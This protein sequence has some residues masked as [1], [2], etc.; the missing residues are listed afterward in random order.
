MRNRVYALPKI[1]TCEASEV[2]SGVSLVLVGEY[3]RKHKQMFDRYEYLENLYKGYFAI[4]KQPAKE[5]WKPDNRLTVPFPK[6]ITDTFT[7]YGY[8]VPI[9]ETSPNDSINDRLQEFQRDNEIT[10]HE[11]EL[12]KKCCIY[13]HAFEYIYQN[14]EGRTKLTALTPKDIFVVYDDTIKNRALFAVR[15]GYHSDE[16]KNA[17]TP[18]GEVMTASEVYEFD[19]NRITERRPNPYGYIPCVEWRFNDERTGL[20]E[21]VSRLI[22]QYNHTISEKANDVDAFAEAYLAILGAEVDDEDIYR[23]RDKRII[24]FYGTDN[25]QDVL[26]QFLTKPTADATQENLLDRLEQEIY[27]TSMV[28]NISDEAFGNA[29]S[30]VSLAYKL[31]AMSN[32]AKMFDRKIEKSIRKR[33]KVWAS[34]STNTSSPDDYLDIEITM[35][36]NLPKNIQE[37]AATAASLEGIVSKE[38]QLKV[39][40][41]VDDPKEEIEKMEKEK[42][43]SIDIYRQQREQV[44]QMNNSEQ[45]PDE[46][47]EIENEQEQS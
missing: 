22:E 19:N 18:Y 4:D 46:P 28:A 2:E 9:K 20:Y 39:L 44:Q 10:D 13:G 36:R 1:L 16:A 45:A 41:I 8:G 29:A 40:S 34:L 3:I 7:G 24:N 12:I 5:S 25:A 14:E 15:Y 33:Y 11:A 30:G 31:Q 32:L 27:Q 26:V 47:N 21:Q 42:N 43:D 37:E 17:R 35:T 38:T 23:I 6:Y